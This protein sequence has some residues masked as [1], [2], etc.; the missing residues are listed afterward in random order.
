MNLHS[1]AVE[2]STTF[3][4][5]SV[6]RGTV[7]FGKSSIRLIRLIGDV[8]LPRT[9]LTVCL[10]TKVS[11]GRLHCKTTSIHMEIRFEHVDGTIYGFGKPSRSNQSRFSPSELKYLRTSMNEVFLPQ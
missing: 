1:I 8:G 6:Y 7:A 11:L 10:E 3:S 5:R 9:S 2:A 4:V